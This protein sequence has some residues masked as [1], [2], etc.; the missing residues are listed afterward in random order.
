MGQV[1]FTTT[2]RTQVSQTGDVTRPEVKKSVNPLQAWGFG[3]GYQDA[4]GFA[5]QYGSVVPLPTRLLFSR[6]KGLS[7]RVKVQVRSNCFLQMYNRAEALGR[8]RRRGLLR[9]GT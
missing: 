3:L 6:M 2:L 1:T 9:K 8:V 4:M 5:P 7:L